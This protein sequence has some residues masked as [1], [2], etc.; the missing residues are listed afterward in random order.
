MSERIITIE[1]RLQNNSELVNYLND[2]VTTYEFTKRKIWHEYI[3]PDYNNLYS[4][5]F[6]RLLR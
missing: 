6:R 3:D 2:A 4:K 1:T 5:E